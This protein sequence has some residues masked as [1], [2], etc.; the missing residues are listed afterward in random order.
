MAI[1]NQLLFGITTDPRDGNILSLTF[2]Y[3]FA[4][5]KRFTVASISPETNFENLSH[6]NGRIARL[7]ECTPM[8]ICQLLV[9]STQR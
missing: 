1:R 4:N 9:F 3:D 2:R 6:L 5:D 7:L 8:A